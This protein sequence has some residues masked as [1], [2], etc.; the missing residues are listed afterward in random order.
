MVEGD[1]DIGERKEKLTS[2]YLGNLSKKEV[3]GRRGRDEEICG[4]GGHTKGRQGSMPVVLTDFPGTEWG[5]H[6][7]GESGEK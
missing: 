5:G 7:R 6:I 4:E 1:Y 3:G 2:S